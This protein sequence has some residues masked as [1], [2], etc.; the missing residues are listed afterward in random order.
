[1]AVVHVLI[2]KWPVELSVDVGAG[3]ASSGCAVGDMLSETYA[4][5]FSKFRSADIS[6]ALIC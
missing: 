5:K 2:K 3:V 6:F 4:L 1:M